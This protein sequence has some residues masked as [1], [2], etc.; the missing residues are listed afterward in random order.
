MFC[1]RATVCTDN[2]ALAATVGAGARV[3]PPGDPVPLAAACIPLLTDRPQRR[4]L[5]AAC[6]ALRIRASASRGVTFDSLS[7]ERRVKSSGHDSE[8][9]RA[10]RGRFVGR[11]H[12]YSRFS[13]T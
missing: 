5:G 8:T 10:V 6:A 11:P 1:G 13:W 2:G 3:V 7:C 9:G 4:E 12:R